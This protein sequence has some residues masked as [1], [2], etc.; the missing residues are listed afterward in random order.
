MYRSDRNYLFS[1][2]DLAGVLDANKCRIRE[3]V[4]A[5]TQSRYWHSLGLAPERFKAAP[6]II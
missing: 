4:E 6:M 1:E 5:R 2:G 3:L